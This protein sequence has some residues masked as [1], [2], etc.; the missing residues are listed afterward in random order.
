M[1]LPSIKFS[2]LTRSYTAASSSEQSSISNNYHS[3]QIFIPRGG[4]QF[5]MQ[6][7][8]ASRKVIKNDPT[9]LLNIQFFGKNFSSGMG[10]YSDK[11]INA[12]WT[13]TLK[14]ETTTKKNTTAWIEWCRENS[15]NSW[16]GKTA[17]QFQVLE[18]ANIFHID[19]NEK[20]KCLLKEYPHRANHNYVDWERVA[21]NFDAVHCTQDFF[22]PTWDCESTAW[23]NK[24][25]LVF[26]KSL[27]SQEIDL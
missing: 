3:S 20:Y 7:L 15:E 19:S 26:L 8:L 24:D 12:F 18:T 5:D 13:C 14:K 25:R 2:Q 17:A 9:A 21:I 16:L 1:N 22:L 27:N 6:R 11:P 10:V 4:Q 23:F